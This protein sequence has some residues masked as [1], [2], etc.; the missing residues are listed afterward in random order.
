MTAKFEIAVFAEPEH[1][2]VRDHFSEADPDTLNMVADI[3]ERAREGDTWA[4][5][6]V[7][8]TVACG[9]LAQHEYLGGC[10]YESEA[11][12]R[13]NSG[14]FDDMVQAC[15]ERLIAG[16]RAVLAAAGEEG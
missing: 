16:A 11:D 14:Y 9:D 5:C 13:A 7:R 8:V 1:D 3:E 6:C 15:M 2:S 12:F 4:W 10:S